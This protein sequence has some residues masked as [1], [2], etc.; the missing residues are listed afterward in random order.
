MEAELGLLA[1]RVSCACLLVL[2]FHGFT[3]RGTAENFSWHS[4]WP[5]SLLLTRVEAEAWLFLL[6]HATAAAILTLPN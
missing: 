1:S 4:H 5:W 2:D 6:G 3:E